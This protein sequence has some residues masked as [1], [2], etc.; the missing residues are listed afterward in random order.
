MC[1]SAIKPVLLSPKYWDS[2]SKSYQIVSGLIS[3]PPCAITQL[4]Y[5]PHKTNS[6]ALNLLECG[7]IQQATKKQRYRIHSVLQTNYNNIEVQ[8]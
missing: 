7:V 8:T 6:A 2:T 1:S 3:R 4:G 5:G